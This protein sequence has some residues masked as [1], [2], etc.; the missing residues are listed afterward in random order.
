MREILFR[1]I[2]ID[3]GEWAEGSLSMVDARSQRIG[4]AHGQMFICKTQNAWQITKGGRLIGYWIE[5]KPE[6]VGQYT[7]AKD[8]RETDLFENDII[9]ISSFGRKYQII[10][11]DEECRF[12][13]IHI[14]K[15]GLNGLCWGSLTKLLEYDFEII[16]NIHEGGNN[17]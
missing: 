8:K 11:S 16:G 15:D 13:A 12:Q 14:S 1:G 6:T 4:N 2:R 3:N 5:V 17:G 9:T 10:W 7:G